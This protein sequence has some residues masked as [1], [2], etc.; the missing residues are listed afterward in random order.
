MRFRESM[1]QCGRKFQGAEKLMNLARDRDG[2]AAEA[3]VPAVFVARP[4]VCE[5]RPA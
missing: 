4:P 1:I 5:K 2:L 3:S